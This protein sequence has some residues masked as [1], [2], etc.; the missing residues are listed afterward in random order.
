LS[1][2]LVVIDTS[3]VIAALTTDEENATSRR[4]IK[5]AGT[6][7]VR[8]ALSDEFLREA[9]EIVRRKDRE[10]QI[11]S[12][13]LAFEVALDLWSHG[14]L[15]YPTKHDWPSVADRED[16]WVPD[17]AWEAEADFIAALDPHLTR[18]S[19][20]FPIEVL[21]PHALAYRLGL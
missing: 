14:S 8:V 5:A 9:V 10:G 16:Y 20:P 12:A 6:G 21:E 2:P 3:V 18:A 1:S 11:V 13:S 15:Y 19:L 7:A 17:L 4:L